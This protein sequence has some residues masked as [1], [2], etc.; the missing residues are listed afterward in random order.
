VADPAANVSSSTPGAAA[1]PSGSSPTL[2]AA[3][4]FSIEVQ[5]SLPRSDGASLPRAGSSLPRSNV[6]I[7][8]L[9]G[10]GGPPAVR[11]ASS[12][13]QANSFHG[14]QRTTSALGSIVSH[15][16]SS[17]PRALSGQLSGSL[18]PAAEAHLN[19]EFTELE[20]RNAV[21]TQWIDDLQ[22]QNQ[23][24]QEAQDSTEEQLEA[25]K[26][27]LK[28]VTDVA[29]SDRQESTS[30]ISEL[31]EKLAK[32]TRKLDDKDSEVRGLNYEF[33]EVK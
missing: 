4:N 29:E 2:L 23:Q 28:A 31:E 24:L 13:L 12:S 16:S 10:G 7:P 15:F 3:R 14:H 17:L 27:Q 6:G 30:K 25:V 9:V 21:L 8:F 20:N 22:I 32:E 18:P 26:R 5:R 11:G 33:E 1:G 19:K